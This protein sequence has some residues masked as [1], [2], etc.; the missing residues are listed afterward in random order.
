MKNQ[1]GLTLIQFLL[2]LLVGG[3]VALWLVDYLRAR[4][5]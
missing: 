4:L 3:V 2:I 1:R 5:A